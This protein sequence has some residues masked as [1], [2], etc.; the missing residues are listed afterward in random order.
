MNQMR[1]RENEI[2]RILLE[3]RISWSLTYNPVVNRFG[4]AAKASWAI[5]ARPTKTDQEWKRAWVYFQT[6]LVSTVLAD[7]GLK[8]WAPHGDDWPRSAN[9]FKPSQHAR[10]VTKHRI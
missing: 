5:T 1:H 7:R 4:S 8:D 10:L 9:A 6:R 3:K 2:Y